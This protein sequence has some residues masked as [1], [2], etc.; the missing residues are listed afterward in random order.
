MSKVK[1]VIFT[2]NF[3][4]W[5]KT[6]KNYSNIGHVEN[7]EQRKK[8][9]RS[10]QTENCTLSVDISKESPST[11][12]KKIYKIIRPHIYYIESVSLYPKSILFEK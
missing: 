11:K 4:F 3:V 10:A 2:A 9:W 1:L 5:T 12:N 8:S 7:Y 6:E